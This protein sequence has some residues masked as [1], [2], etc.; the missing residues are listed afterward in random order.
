M[1]TVEC[2]AK[3]HKNMSAE[4]TTALAAE[5]EGR[6]SDKVDFELMVGGIGKHGLQLCSDLQKDIYRNNASCMSVQIEANLAR[7]AKRELPR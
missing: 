7:V 1:E 2:S 6:A 4:L 5:K 3:Y